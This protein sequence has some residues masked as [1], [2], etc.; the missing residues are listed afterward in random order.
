VRDRAPSGAPLRSIQELPRVRLAAILLG[1]LLLELAGA[2]DGLAQPVTVGSKLPY[3]GNVSPT[4]TQTTISVFGATATGFVTSAT[5][6]WSVT[7]CPAAVKI[8]F[9]RPLG[10]GFFN[11]VAERGPFDVTAPLTPGGTVPPVV[12]TVA[13]DP[14]VALRQGDVIAITNVT[15]CGGPTWSFVGIPLPGVTPPIWSYTFDGDVTSGVGPPAASS[16]SYVPYVSAE[17]PSPGLGLLNGRFEIQL[18]ATNPR[19]GAVTLGTAQAVDDTAGYFSLPDFTGNPNVP[20]IT[21]KMVDATNAAPPFGG[22]FWFFYSSLTDVTY[23]LTVI[24]HRTGARREYGSAGS[25]AF[26]GGGDTNA[27][28][29]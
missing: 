28:P 6:G 12:Q 29:P 4:R 10:A 5:F 23:T 1:A 16:S 3:V 24:D 2:R 8:K 15:P 7:G 17:G 13:L 14:P 26:C 25:P 19:T 9:F 21:V 18:A 22:A 27:F 20:E 11:F